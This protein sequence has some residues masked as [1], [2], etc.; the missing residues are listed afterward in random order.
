[1]KYSN[2]L[3]NVRLLKS[4]HKLWRYVVLPTPKILVDFTVV[5]R[6]LLYYLKNVFRMPVPNIHMHISTS[7][8]KNVKTFLV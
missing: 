5:Y 6:F 2:T 1:M 7:D 8:E 3:R 4:L